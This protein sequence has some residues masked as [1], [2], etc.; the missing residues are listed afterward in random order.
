MFLFIKEIIEMGRM[1]TRIVMSRLR[2]QVRK[3]STE[4]IRRSLLNAK[5][6]LEAGKKGSAVI[7]ELFE[8]ELRYRG[9]LK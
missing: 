9:E 6:D 1:T 2:S 5:E 7:V 4:R 8:D 3:M